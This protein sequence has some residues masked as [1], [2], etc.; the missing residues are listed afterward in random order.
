MRED[1]FEKE[2]RSAEV[3]PGILED[4]RETTEANNTNRSS[5]EI[6]T[7]DERT[8]EEL[9]TEILEVNQK[10]DA[11]RA[12]LNAVREKCGLPAVQ[13]S[14]AIEGLEQRRAQLTKEWAYDINPAI[15]HYF[16]E[17]LGEQEATKRIDFLREH[18]RERSFVQLRDAVLSG[19]VPMVVHLMEME[20]HWKLQR[21]RLSNDPLNRQA[22]RD[23]SEFQKLYGKVRDMDVITDQ[24]TSEVL[25]T[26]Q[27]LRQYEPPVQNREEEE[28][29]RIFTRIIS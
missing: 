12:A 22:D 4:K 20:R 24:H 29:V 11:E 14:V 6:P 17:D 10:I 9:S 25:S 5:H 7:G 16:M 13:T 27:D 28:F 2:T 3:N 21:E 18:G 26:V 19:N 23:G 1:H 8:S 15:V